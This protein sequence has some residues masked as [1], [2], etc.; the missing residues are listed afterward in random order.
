MHIPS[1]CLSLSGGADTS[2]L[3][4]RSAHFAWTQMR[5]ICTRYAGADPH[6]MNHFI[7]CPW[8]SCVAAFAAPLFVTIILTRYGDRWGFSFYSYCLGFRVP[9]AVRFAHWGAGLHLSQYVLC[10]CRGFSPFFLRKKIFLIRWDAPSCLPRFP[11]SFFP[12]LAWVP[13]SCP[14]SSWPPHSFF[15]SFLSPAKFCIMKVGT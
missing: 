15:V 3:Q 4:K 11:A 8:K 6:T 12:A 1:A 7:T 14:A 5:R 10:Q 13:L 2:S 9:C